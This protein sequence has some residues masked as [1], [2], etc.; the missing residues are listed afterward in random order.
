MFSP[1]SHMGVIGVVQI[2]TFKIIFSIKNIDFQNLMCKREDTGRCSLGSNIRFSV[3]LDI[4]S[5]WSWVFQMVFKLKLL[6]FFP[7]KSKPSI[8]KHV[9]LMHVRYHETYAP[10]TRQVCSK[11]TKIL[12]K[13][14]EW[15][16]YSW[17]L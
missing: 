6:L 8:S 15:T 12:P 1:R 9:F 13:Q 2:T 17:N 14:L 4:N 5:Y 10:K 16:K 7:L 11:M 3:Y